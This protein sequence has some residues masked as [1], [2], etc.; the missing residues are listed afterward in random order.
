MTS[1][2]KTTRTPIQLARLYTAAEVLCFSI[3]SLVDGLISKDWFGAMSLLILGAPVLPNHLLLEGASRLHK[4]NPGKTIPALKTVL[5]L[6]LDLCLIV[7][8][9]ILGIGISCIDIANHTF[10]LRQTAPFLIV[11]ILQISASISL[12]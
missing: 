9:I 10:H 4:Q 3:L 2:S 6:H 1:R 5:S 7:S 12:K 11:P 8:V